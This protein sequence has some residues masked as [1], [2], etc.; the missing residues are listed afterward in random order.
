MELT[1]TD[2]RVRKTR[3]QIREA[4]LDLLEEQS[5]ENITISQLAKKAM[6]S[7]STFYDHYPDKYALVDAMYEEIREQFEILTQVYFNTN[8]TDY[9]LDLAQ[10]ILNYVLENA[11]LFRILLSD[12][13]P[14]K[15]LFL[16]FQE[17]LE[18]RCMEYLERNPNKHQ[19][20]NR[21]IVQIYSSIIFLSLQWMAGRQD[22]EDLPK[23]LQMS[24]HVYKLFFD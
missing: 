11:R 7:R 10:D 21:L 16:I 8:H 15:N 22:P 18:P 24:T 17:I 2:L 19:L 9:H 3:H 1:S 13:L 12:R 4:L 20:D 6:I 5:F 23:I 14:S